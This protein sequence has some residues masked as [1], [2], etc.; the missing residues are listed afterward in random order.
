MTILCYSY[1]LDNVPSKLNTT[2]SAP[3]K[4]SDN[5]KFEN[6]DD[7]QPY[8]SISLNAAYCTNCSTVPN[9]LNLL[10]KENKDLQKLQ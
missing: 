6:Y 5:T 4:F 7:I 1:E 10:F 8:M 9:T 2:I 3:G